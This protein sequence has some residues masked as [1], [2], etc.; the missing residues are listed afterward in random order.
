MILVAKVRASPYSYSVLSF[1]EDEREIGFISPGDHPHPVSS[2][3]KSTLP[4][5]CFEIFT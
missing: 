1:I 2:T 3:R 5:D 4:F